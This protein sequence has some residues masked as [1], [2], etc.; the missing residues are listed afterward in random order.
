MKRL[1]LFLLFFV[2][3][4]WMFAQSFSERHLTD[5]VRVQT[6]FRT[7]LH[8]DRNLAGTPILE[9]PAGEDIWVLETIDL[10]VRKVRYYTLVGYVNVRYLE[11]SVPPAR[12][13]FE[14]SGGTSGGGSATGGQGSS[15][16]AG[17]PSV[18][19][20]GT[21]QKGLRCRNITKSC[22]GRCH[23]HGG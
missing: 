4:G 10:D 9:I 11:G 17:C 5:S 7:P 16:P 14:G 8:P 2:L 13:A 12:A 23:Y 6:A 20:T 18:Q 19:C 15:T 22:N 21:T 1:H 3:H